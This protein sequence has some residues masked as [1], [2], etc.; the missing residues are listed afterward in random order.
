[1]DAPRSKKTTNPWVIA[2]VCFGIAGL[3][4]LVAIGG[5]VWWFSAN[6]ERFV[7]LGK[8]SDS[9]AREFSK[10]HDQEACVGEGLRKLDACDGAG[11]GLVCRTAA[12]VFAQSCV[13]HAQPGA[14]VCEDAPAE[15]QIMKTVEYARAQCVKRARQPD[16]QTCSQ[17]MQAVARGCWTRKSAAS[18]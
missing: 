13:A 12:N 14:S 3:L 10:D 6:K 11:G 2:L 7:E 16:D 17:L 4:A 15:G 9:E 5:A 1:M 18:R 8:A